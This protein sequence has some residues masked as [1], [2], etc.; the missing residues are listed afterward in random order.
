M[1]VEK[2]VLTDALGAVK[3]KRAMQK[4]REKEPCKFTQ[5]KS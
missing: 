1:G 2:K 3:R 5:D 4:F